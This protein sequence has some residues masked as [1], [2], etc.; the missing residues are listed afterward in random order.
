LS[1]YSAKQYLQPNFGAF[2]RHASIRFL[3]FAQIG[4]L[5]SI[6]S[7]L[8]STEIDRANANVSRN[9][10][11]DTASKIAIF[12]HYSDDSQISNS[13]AYFISS[14]R[15][16]GFSVVVS[17]TCTNDPLIHQAIWNQWSDRLDGLITRPNLGF[18]FGSWSAAL[19]TINLDSQFLQQILLVN[20]SMYGPLFPLGP[21]I[22]ELSSNG[23]FFGLTASQEFSPHLQS[24]FLGFNRVVITSP[25]FRMFWEGKFGGRSK[26]STIWGR[27]LTW[28]RFFAR[29]GFQSAVLM[30]QTR[31]F[32]RNPLT[33]LWKDLVSEGFPFMKKSLFTHNYDSIDISD[34]KSF[35]RNECPDFD[36]DLI[37]TDING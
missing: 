34:W 7:A 19:S 4:R 32:P 25:M 5:M 24:Y 8:T 22:E 35:L 31:S 17:S 21:M 30:K 18:D 23:D 15:E 10:S 9:D 13:D 26:W 12:A 14:L 2:F 29:S 6:A 28:E 36:T 20:N 3:S 37:T 16:A 1:T 11:L 27:E 33:F